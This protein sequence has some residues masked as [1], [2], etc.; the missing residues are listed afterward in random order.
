MAI[1]PKGVD[2]AERRMVQLNALKSKA[3]LEER[4]KTALKYRGDPE[5]QALFK[6]VKE[7]K[8]EDGK[9]TKR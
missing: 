2:G 6:E 5:I 9:I 4:F 1:N 3:Q 7:E 8:K